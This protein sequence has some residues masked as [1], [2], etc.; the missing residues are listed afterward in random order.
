MLSKLQK[1]ISNIPGWR[2]NRKIIV[3]E[4]DDW[5]SVRMPS[6]QVY[7]ELKNLGVNVYSGD[8]ERFNTLDTLASKEDLDHLFT[9]LRKFKDS[10]GNHPVITA[11]SLCANPDFKKI[12][13]SDFTQYFFEPVT[14]TFERYKM[15]DVLAMWKQGENEKLFYP[16]FHG[17]EHLNI[18][19]WMRDLRNSNPH[20]REAFKR[21]FWGFRNSNESKISYQ[22]AFDLEHRNSLS[23]QKE[24]IKSGLRLFEQL[25]KRRASYF[26]PPN[27][28][29]H[30]EIIDYSVTQG[31]KYVSSPKIHNEPQGNGKTKKRYRYLG[32]KGIGGMIYLT[33]NCFFEPNFKG[34]GFSVSDCLGHIQTAFMFRKPAIIST[35]RVNYVGGLNLQNRVDGNQALEVL[36]NQTL[37]KYPEVE[38][39]TS[40]QLGE[41]MKD[42]K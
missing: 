12:E 38:F 13:Q 27:G 14:V 18:N 10:K 11:L 24:V 36:L 5:G 1:I 22:S 19:V 39:M 23:L 9:T 20:T 4:S 35:H 34:K 25:H 41:L 21:G 3:I 8:N 26:V 32:K 2:T 7:E 30:Q 15:G 33:R 31:I 29:I 16:E 37:K 17:R 6:L 28:A 42:D 40:T